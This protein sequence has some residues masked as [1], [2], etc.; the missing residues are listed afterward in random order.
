VKHVRGYRGEEQA[1]LRQGSKC[2]RSAGMSMNAPD[3]PLVAE[4]VL[5]NSNPV[6]APGGTSA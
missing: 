4:G 3:E 2:L 5:A 6:S 1:S